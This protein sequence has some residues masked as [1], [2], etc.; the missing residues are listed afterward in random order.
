MDRR[1]AALRL[2]LDASMALAWLFERDRAAEAD[3]AARALSLVTKAKTTVPALW[4]IEIANGLLV[5]ERRHVVTQS[6]AA[7]S[8]Q[9][10]RIGSES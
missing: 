6:G 9:R 5:G 7:L 2:V 3:R 1:G 8:L 10:P 4:H